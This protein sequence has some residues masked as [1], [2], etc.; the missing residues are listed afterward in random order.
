[1]QITILPYIWRG[2]TYK[3]LKGVCNA[4]NKHHGGGFAIGFDR[5][6]VRLSNMQNREAPAIR[7]QIA[8]TEAENIIA[9]LPC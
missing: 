2:K 7:Y 9:D 6:Y 4:L 3:S 1:M 5:D 8:R